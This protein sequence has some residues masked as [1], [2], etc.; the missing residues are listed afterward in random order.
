MP[1]INTDNTI[2]AGQTSAPTTSSSSGNTIQMSIEDIRRA[3]ALGELKGINSKKNAQVVDMDGNRITLPS[4][5]FVTKNNIRGWDAAYGVIDPASLSAIDKTQDFVDKLFDAWEDEKKA[6]EALNTSMKIIEPIIFQQMG[7][8]PSYDESGTMTGLTKMTEEEMI[9]NM[10]P[11]ERQNYNIMTET[12]ALN[13]KALRGEMPTSPQLEKDLAKQRQMLEE[14]MSRKLG[15]DWRTTTPGIQAL[16]EFEIK[17]SLIKEEAR[18][19]LMTTAA[20]LT[21]AAQSSLLTSQG[22]TTQGILTAGQTGL[23]GMQIGQGLLSTGGVV[24]QSYMGTLAPAMQSQQI[25]LQQ[26]MVNKQASAQRAAGI[27][28]LFGTVIGTA[29]GIGILR[30]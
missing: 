19:G 24:S 25:A 23:P 30:K 26:W 15:I 12:A 6:Q 7:Y 29:T 3:W 1:Y 17:E 14:T 5:E 9:A 4:G 2:A 21:S 27:A 16:S 22:A 13:L 11:L 20:G 10:S 28:N 18:R 8:N